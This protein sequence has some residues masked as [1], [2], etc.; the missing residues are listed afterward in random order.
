MGLHLIGV[1]AMAL[2]GKVV[3]LWQRLEGL[4]QLD[5]LS[6][7]G[8]KEFQSTLFYIDIVILIYIDRLSIW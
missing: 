1:P 3:G 6:I 4:R 7:W 8:G 2:C 5:R